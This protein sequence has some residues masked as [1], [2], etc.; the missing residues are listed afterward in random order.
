[1][2]D[3]EIEHQSTARMIPKLL[4]SNYQEVTANR[5]GI[6]HFKREVGETVHKGTVIATIMNLYGNVVEEVKSDI[7]GYLIAYSLMGNQ[8]V[9]TGDLV[10]F[11]A[12]D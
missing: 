5:G 6:V 8:A 11:I 1:M 4:G 2:L 10:A 3:G 9:N 12:S 7:D